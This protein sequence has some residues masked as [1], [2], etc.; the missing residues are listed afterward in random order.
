MAGVRGASRFGQFFLA[1]I[2]ILAGFGLASA[3]PRM[4]RLAVAVAVL[5]L[6]A[7]NLEALRAPINYR[8]FDGLS[9]NFDALASEPENTIVACYPFPPPLEAFHNVDCMLASTRFWKPLVNGYSSFMPESYARSAQALAA[10]P[11][12]DTL[13]YLKSL[14]VTHVIVFPRKV[15]APRLERVD[16]HPDQLVLWKADES[17]RIYRLR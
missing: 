3:M 5:V 1:A 12:G 14:G 4:R 16:A 17:A 8:R 13:A 9:P 2:A 10:F 6:L 15:S 11:E 7:A